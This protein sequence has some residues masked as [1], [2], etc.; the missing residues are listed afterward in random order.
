MKAGNLVANGAAGAA[1]LAASLGCLVLGVLAV[2]GDGSKA[3]TRLLTFYRP[4]GPLSGVSTVAIV[5]WLAAWL[6]G[7]RVWRGKTIA[8]GKVCGAAFVFLGLALLLTFP[9]VG[10]LLLGK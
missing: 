5:V 8:L 10:D 6:V 7:N 4:T 1:I 3:L 9:P 2:A